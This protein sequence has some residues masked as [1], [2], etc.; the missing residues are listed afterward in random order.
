M[1]SDSG[2]IKNFI[3]DTNVIL[4]SPKC[5]ETFENN[6]IYIPAIVIEE[7]DSFKKN[8]D[9][10][11]Y[12]ARQ[13]IRVVEE[14]RHDGDLTE[15]VDLPC[16]G[17]LFVVFPEKGMMELLPD[18]FNPSKP[19]NRILA[20]ALSIKKKSDRETILV[21]KDVNLRI[22]ANLVN[23]ES[24]DYYHDQIRSFYEEHDD[25][26]YVN[27]SYLN[28]L[29][30]V[31]ELDVST[32]Y[33]PNDE[34]FAPR[35]NEYFLLKSLDDSQ[36]GT[37]VK[38]MEYED[39]KRTFRKLLI[40][41]SL[42]GIIPV[43]RKQKYLL[44]SLLDPDIDVVFAIGIAGSGKTLLALCAGLFTV[45]NDVYK[46]MIVTRSPIPMGRD[47]G[48]LPGGVHDKMDPWLKPIYDNLE[49]II[50]RMERGARDVKEEFL[51]RGQMHDI[52]IEYLKSA[53]TLE[54][55]ALTYIRGRTLMDTFVVIDEAQNLSPHEIK[56]IITRAGVNSKL[57]FTGDLKQIDNPYLNER[58]NGLINA[59][60]KFTFSGY[61]HASTIYLDK[62]E[63]SRLASIAAE[64]L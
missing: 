13:F 49:F 61:K 45:L 1:T 10:N 35:V 20:T 57:V 47:I 4:Y 62:G 52:T 12:N 51:S 36:K 23:M 25:T 64:V 48:Y 44:D 29:N 38:F 39:G 54:I 3:L 9:I 6:Y 46:R 30:N 16:G 50:S 22:K 19:D 53:K 42:L 63:R 33:M 40:P 2:K 27:D 24:D 26:I 31:N 7:V 59:S 21:T 32:V 60:E 58:D 15:G 56:T 55:E 17:K 37:L 28:E 5:L 14:F 11:G 18:G 8:V 43:N 41:D 34:E